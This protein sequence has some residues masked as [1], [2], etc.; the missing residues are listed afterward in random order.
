M[1][2]GID[3]NHFGKVSIVQCDLI[4]VGGHVVSL[5]YRDYSLFSQ[6]YIFALLTH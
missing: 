6:K 5:R 3:A 4:E 2:L 1:I